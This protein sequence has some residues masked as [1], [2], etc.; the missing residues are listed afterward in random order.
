MASHAPVLQFR[1]VVWLLPIAYTIH[2][3]EEAVF[4]PSWSAEVGLPSPVGP[5]A[6]RF[7]VAVVS[8]ASWV[9]AFLAFRGPPRGLAAHAAAAA[10]GILLLNV[11]I[12]HVLA[13]IWVGGYAPGV[14]SAVGFNLW[15]SPLVLRAAFR[16]GMVSRRGAALATVVGGLALL[17]GVTVLFWVGGLLEPSS[18]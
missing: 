17:L 6:F 7:A 13:A 9:V 4:Q 15:V 11:F 3:L 2:D 5:F 1:A 8:A 16:E 12:P 14:V 18:P 10:A